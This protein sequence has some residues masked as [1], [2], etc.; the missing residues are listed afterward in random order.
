MRQILKQE[1]K[2]HADDK[3]QT[4]L[5]TLATWVDGIL[6]GNAETL[7]NT[8]RLRLVPKPNGKARPIAIG[9]VV[10]AAAKRIACEVIMKDAGKWLEARG[11][12]GVSKGGTTR[13]AEVMA[14]AYAKGW[15]VAKMDVSNAFNCVHRSAVVDVV[16][17]VAPDVTP[18]VRAALQPTTVYGHGVR[19][20]VERGVMQGDPMASLLFSLVMGRVAE[21]VMRA[22]ATKGVK[23][24][25]AGGQNGTQTRNALSDALGEWD[26]VMLWYADDGSMAWKCPQK[27]ETVMEVISEQLREVGLKLSGGKCELVCGNAAAIADVDRASDALDMKVVRAVMLLGVPVGETETSRKLVMDEVEAKYERLK[28]SWELER[29]LAEVA[30][31]RQTG[32]CVAL[33]YVLNA[34]PPG[35]VNQEVLD[36]IRNREDEL[37]RHVFGDYGDGAPEAVMRQARHPLKAGGLGLLTIDGAGMLVDGKW[38]ARTPA[39]LLQWNKANNAEIDRLLLGPRKEAERKRVWE[40]RRGKEIL[41]WAGCA[42][43]LRAEGWGENARVPTKVVESIALFAAL[44]GHVIPAEAVGKHCPSNHDKGE[45]PVLGNGVACHH[46][47]CEKWCIHQ[48]HAAVQEQLVREISRFRE[49]EREQTVNDEGVAMPRGRGR[50]AR[51]QKVLGDVVF[52]MGTSKRIYLDVTLGSVCGKTAAMDVRN[53]ETSEWIGRQKQTKYSDVV[54]QHK[55]EFYPIAISTSGHMAQLGRKKLA[56]W[57][58]SEAV[59]RVVCVAMMAQAE[60]TADILERVLSE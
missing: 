20:V 19:R 6:G 17:E 36:L 4:A 46:E 57:C 9:D 59:V 35:I 23:I 10:P 42:L 47:K 43:S 8:M 13:A 56:R 49:V 30:C 58:S 3:S 1:G 16:S 54:K 37:I 31:L 40:L 55:L 22:A 33:K 11:Q 51:G 26:V 21:R 29:P 44:G 34:A 52:K 5:D 7:T 48:R 38:R 18:F 24:L 15:H 39:E 28:R 45:R 27:L 41:K 2:P 60:I 50:H 14:T 25:L 53:E 12:W 32:M